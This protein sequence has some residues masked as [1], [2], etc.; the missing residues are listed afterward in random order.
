[1]PDTK[2][3]PTG[4]MKSKAFANIRPCKRHRSHRFEYHFYW[5]SYT[6]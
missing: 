3:R 1:M 4:T 5:I 2:L 6:I